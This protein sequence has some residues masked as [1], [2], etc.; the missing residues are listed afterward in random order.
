[1]GGLRPHPCL[2]SAYRNQRRHPAA[3]AQCGRRHPRTL[4]IRDAAC[5]RRAPGDPERAEEVVRPADPGLDVSL[6]GARRALADPRAGRPGALG[7][8]CK[9]RRVR[10]YGHNRR[11]VPAKPIGCDHPLLRDPPNRTDLLCDIARPV[12]PVRWRGGRFACAAEAVRIRFRQPDGLAGGWR[13]TPGHLD[14]AD[15][16]A[17]RV[18]APGPATPAR[19]HAG[20]S[21]RFRRR[22]RAA[23]CRAALCGPNVA[24]DCAPITRPAIRRRERRSARPPRRSR[25][26]DY[27]PAA[28]R[29]WRARVH[30]ARKCPRSCASCHRCRY[31]W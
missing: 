31:P 14:D 4:G 6:H 17:R 24:G 13:R 11:A 15:H 25:A 30:R 23:I 9:C 19:R 10:V 3:P 18:Q 27:P 26:H 28:H 16:I 29:G 7:I 2:V 12:R 1:M 8:A 21:P 20:S 5:I 22:D